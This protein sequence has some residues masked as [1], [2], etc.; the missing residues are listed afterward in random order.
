MK[1][2]ITRRFAAY[3]LNNYIGNFLGFIVGSLS[4]RLVANY[5]TTRSIRNLWGLTAH[6][7]IVTKHTYTTLEWSV[8]ILVGF[9]VFELVSKWLQKLVASLLPKYKLTR[10]MVQPQ[11]EA[12]KEA[13]EQ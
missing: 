12:E 5:F 6:K 10:W 8:S 4:S 3:L 13:M 9:I 11:A 2:G 7:T 1:G